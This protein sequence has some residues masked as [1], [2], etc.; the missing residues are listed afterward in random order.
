[1]TS[2]PYPKSW[3]TMTNSLDLT[4]LQLILNCHICKVGPTVLPYC[5]CKMT[6]WKSQV[7]MSLC[8]FIHCSIKGWRRERRKVRTR[9]NWAHEKV[10]ADFLSLLRK[11]A[12]T[13]TKQALK[14]FVTSWKTCVCVCVCVT[15]CYSC[16]LLIAVRHCEKKAAFRSWFLKGKFPL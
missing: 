12:D 11:K 6:S 9:W 7:R 10:K 1:M 3:V 4:G 5:G 15:T 14:F 2:S 8:S 16:N 13:F